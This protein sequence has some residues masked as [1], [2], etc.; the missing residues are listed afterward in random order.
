MG[1]EPKDFNEELMMLREQ[2]VMYRGLCA[3]FHTPG[4]RPT[5]DISIKIGSALVS[6]IFNRSQRSFAHVPTV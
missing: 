5:N 2:Q 1:P 4:A 6:N 3:N